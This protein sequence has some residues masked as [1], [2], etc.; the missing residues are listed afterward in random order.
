[1]DEYLASADGALNGHSRRSWLIVLGIS[2]VSV[3]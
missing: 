3:S 2:F 1:M